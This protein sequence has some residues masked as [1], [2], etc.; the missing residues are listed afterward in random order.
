MTPTERILE[1]IDN[2]RD[3][4]RDGFA[5]VHADVAQLRTELREVST[6]Q[7]EHDRRDTERK[8]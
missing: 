5:H 2:I 7:R 4:Q 1:R 6:L 8:P 3:E